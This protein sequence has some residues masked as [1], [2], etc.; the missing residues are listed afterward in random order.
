MPDEQTL[1]KIKDHYYKIR[2][3]LGTHKSP[4]LHGAIPVDAYSHTPSGSGAQQPGL[5]GQ[6]KEDF[7]ARF[8][9]LGIVIK[10]GTIA[11]VPSMLNKGEMLDRDKV[12]EF[13]DLEGE[14]RKL[15]LHL[16]QLAFTICQVPVVY[17][18]GTKQEI[19]IEYADGKQKT[20]QGSVIDADTSQKIFRR[21]GE[22]RKIAFTTAIK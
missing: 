21:N 19:T 15:E 1:G 4:A 2:H 3:G 8:G 20:I 11:F 18:A 14:I 9:E 22:V 6:V 16:N 5:T 17:T 13:I 10:E 7:V 12:F